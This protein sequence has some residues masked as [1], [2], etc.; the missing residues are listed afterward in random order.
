MLENEVRQKEKLEEEIS[1]L[2]NQ[3]LQISFD[4]DETRKQLES[5]DHSVDMNGDMGSLISPIRQPQIK[6]S[7]EQEKGPVAK[8]FEQGNFNH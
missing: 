3:L 1:M 2:Q 7:R 8:L 4:A 5:G 6:Y